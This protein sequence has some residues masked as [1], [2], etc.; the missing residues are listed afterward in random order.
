MLHSAQTGSSGRNT[1]TVEA[2]MRYHLVSAALLGAA[3][4]LELGGFAG[5]TVMLAGG[6]ACEFW[7]WSRIARHRR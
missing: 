5:V 7:F 4:V 2:V 6:I 1:R 3:I